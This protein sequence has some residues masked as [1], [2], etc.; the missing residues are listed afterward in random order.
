M[1]LKMKNHR[2]DPWPV[3]QITQSTRNQLLAIDLPVSALACRQS[4]PYALHWNPD[5]LRPR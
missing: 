1:N 5:G 2:F 3:L 4:S